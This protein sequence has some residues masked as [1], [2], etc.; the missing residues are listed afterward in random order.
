MGLPRVRA[1]LTMKK[2]PMLSRNQSR[3][4]RH[5]NRETAVRSQVG[6]ERQWAEAERLAAKL[7]ELGIDPDES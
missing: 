3:E 4:Q 1:A 6:T 2:T 7:R 5:A